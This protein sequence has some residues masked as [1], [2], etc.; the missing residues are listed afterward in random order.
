MVHGQGPTREWLRL[1]LWR[2]GLGRLLGSGGKEGR[3]GYTRRVRV[4]DCHF[5]SRGMELERLWVAFM[6]S[7]GGRACVYDF[8]NF[9][10]LTVALRD[11]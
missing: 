5:D 6:S 4:T 7:R 3:V 9:K 10:Y 2:A 8:C 1:R 11:P